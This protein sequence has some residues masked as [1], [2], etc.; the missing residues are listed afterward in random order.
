MPWRRSSAAA[1][2]CRSTSSSWRGP[3]PPTPRPPRAA[4]AW[5]WAACPAAVVAT[6]SEELDALAPAA[7]EL[8][9][10]RRGGGRAVRARP[11]R[12][13]RGRGARG[14][15]W[16]RS[17]TCSRRTSCAPTPVP[18]RFAFRHPI[19]RQA[20]YE[21]LRAGRRLAAHAARGRG[22]RGARRVRVRARARTS[23][24]SAAQGDEAAIARAARGRA[25]RRSGA[26]RRRRCAGTRP[27]CGCCPAPTASSRWRSW[28]LLAS[29]LRAVGRARALPHDAARRAR[30]AAA[31][32][33]GARAS[34]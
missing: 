34:S 7:R 13:R 30:A 2:A 32:G 22:A 31:A 18:R 20:V 8:L 10:A 5:R 11:R 26:R 6:L 4:T 19:V 29:A 12:G 25:M 15:A 17:T 23:S 9:D 3:G 27:R 28:S 24:M 21:S 33:R 1:A 16:M 14:R